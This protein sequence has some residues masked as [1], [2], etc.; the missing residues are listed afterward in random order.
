MRTSGQKALLI[1]GV[2]AAGVLLGAGCV[3]GIAFFLLRGNEK[4]APPAR[5]R[6]LST[7]RSP[8]LCQWDQP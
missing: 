6:T 3:G 7:L 2:A 5:S 4:K 8:A 1:G